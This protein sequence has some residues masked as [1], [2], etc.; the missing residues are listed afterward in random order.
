MQD[1][2]R[3]IGF[4]GFRTKKQLQPLV[5]WVL[6]K[7]DS[8]NIV[9]GEEDDTNLAQ[10]CREIGGHAGISVVG[11]IDERGRLVPEYF[12]PYLVSSYVSSDAHLSCER[13]SKR[14]AFNGMCEDY[15][16]GM[17]LIFSVRNV[18]DAARAEQTTLL[19]DGFHEVLISALAKDGTVLLPLEQT[20]RVLLQRAEEEKTRISL[21]EDAN[22]GNEDA[23]AN[24]AEQ[25][26]KRYHRVMDQ[27][28][29]SDIYSVVES[30]FMPFGMESDQYYFMG[31]VQES[32]RIENEL[33]G[34]HFYRII[35]K[36]NGM[37]FAIAIN[38]KDL[39]GV[40]M[41]GTRIK[42]HAWLQG[43]LRR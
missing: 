19:G 32:S 13:E 40:P 28:R 5:N 9:A 30:F 36:S 10:A 43:E 38:E 31:Q 3:A 29:D 11:E 15:R 23:A 6:E 18:A 42:C 4:S 24:L 7:P 21:M 41:P 17:A 8:M 27:L 39:E 26:M 14:N 35:A 33:T 16:M 2:L 12:F 1:F 20:E 25:E 37:P 22:A 34:E